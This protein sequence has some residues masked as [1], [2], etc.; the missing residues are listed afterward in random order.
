MSS[1]C[2]L[3]TYLKKLHSVIKLILTILCGYNLICCTITII[4]L[5]YFRISS[6]QTITVCGLLQLT[7]ITPGILTF[8]MLCIISV[9]RYYMTWK[10]NQ[11]ELFKTHKILLSVG[12]VYFMEHILGMFFFIIAY[13]DFSLMQPSSSCAGKDILDIVP[14]MA[15]FLLLKS[16]I[17]CAIGIN[18][19]FKLIKLLK[20]R[21]LQSVG[22][23]ET[24][25]IPWKSSNSDESDVKVPI[26]ATIVT[27]SFISIAIARVTYINIFNKSPIHWLRSVIMC[28]ATIGVV[29]P[30][31]LF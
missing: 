27:L 11:L 13:M 24:Q 26:R 19:D 4:I 28:E 16:V 3:H 21:K 14:V 23:R 17:V 7:T 15:Y 9:V 29:I 5:V 12:A 1:L 18:Y 30:V 25:I 6:Q 8:H 20:K 22:H 2:F 31:L 10:T